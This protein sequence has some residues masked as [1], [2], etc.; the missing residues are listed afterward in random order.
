MK[1]F[2][3]RIAT[4]MIAGASI[5]L[6]FLM[7]ITF[8]D[9]VGRY[10]FSAPLTFSV[11]VIQLAMGLMIFLGL[12]VT[13]LELRHISV[14]VI[15]TLI[16][17]FLRSLLGGF[18]AIASTI[19]FALVAWQ[20]WLRAQS[21]MYDGLATQVLFLP[22]YPVVFAMAL[23]ASFVAVISFYQLILTIKSQDARDGTPGN[24]S[25]ENPHRD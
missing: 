1:S 5:C 3:G 10:F 24:K 15:I 11:E 17:R 25:A 22:V 21:F 14:D 2:F 12:A 16:P 9:V 6:V 4:W 20:L 7:L 19:F 8:V 18:S 13:T 23:A